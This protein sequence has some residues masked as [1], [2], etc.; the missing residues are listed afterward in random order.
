MKKQYILLMGL[1]G[2]LPRMQAMQ[3]DLPKELIDT[4]VNVYFKQLQ[5]DV[6]NEDFQSIKQHFA[7][8]HNSVFKFNAKHGQQVQAILGQAAG[9]IFSYANKVMAS[10]LNRDEK[11]DT[12][13]SLAFIFVDTAYHQ[14]VSEDIKKLLGQPSVAKYVEPIK[15]STPLGYLE[16][17]MKEAIAQEN[18]T[19]L[20]NV[21]QEAKSAQAIMIAQQ[22]EQAIKNLQVKLK[23]EEAKKALE[24]AEFYEKKDIQMSEN[25]DDDFN[26]IEATLRRTAWSS[27]QEDLNELRDIFM[28]LKKGDSY[29]EEVKRAIAKIKAKRKK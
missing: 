6:K 13:S 18:I 29:Y 17:K 3:P 8:L 4:S 9:I 19:K 2:I 20:K 28:T 11:L 15:K 7:K 5:Q 10:N 26:Y 16:R 23:E 22:I 24:D 25:G 27:D 1:L 12:L 14:I 21:L